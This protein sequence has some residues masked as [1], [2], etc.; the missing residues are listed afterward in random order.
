MTGEPRVIPT[1]DVLRALPYHAPAPGWHSH[2]LTLLPT[3]GCA[4]CA[5]LRARE[6][7]CAAA[8]GPAP[9]WRDVADV[10]CPACADRCC[11]ACYERAVGLRCPCTHTRRSEAT[12]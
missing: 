9:E 8:G 4:A 12:Q 10:P 6:A 11:I 2:G 1:A 5:E 7:E 3:D